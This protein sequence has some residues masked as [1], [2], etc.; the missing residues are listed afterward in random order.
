MMKTIN[1]RDDSL[2]HNSG[3]WSSMKKKKRCV[4]LAE[5]FYEWQKKGKEKVV[6]PSS[7]IYKSLP[8]I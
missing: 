4:V 7:T 1:C 6:L 3:M 2:L 8:N 5:G